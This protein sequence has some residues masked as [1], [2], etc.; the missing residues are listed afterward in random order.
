V[1]RGG[2]TFFAPP[3]GQTDFFPVHPKKVTLL[4]ETAKPRLRF[5]DSTQA[6]LDAELREIALPRGEIGNESQTDFF[7]VDPKKVLLF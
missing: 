3:W 4:P 6:Q 7:G 2:R 5:V 1:N